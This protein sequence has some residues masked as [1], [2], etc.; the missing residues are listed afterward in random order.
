VA[1]LITDK[2]HVAWFLMAV[3]NSCQTEAV[4]VR[5]DR[6]EFT[7]T[8]L[9]AVRKHVARIPFARTV[10]RPVTTPP[11]F[12]GELGYGFVSLDSTFFDVFY[13]CTGLGAVGKHVTRIVLAFSVKCPSTAP[14]V[15]VNKH[16]LHVFLFCTGLG[17]VRK[18]VARIP[19]AR[20]VMCPCTAPLI[21]VNKS[22]LGIFLC[23][24]GLRAVLKH[25]T[26]IVL[27]RSV[28]SPSTTPP[29]FIDRIS[30][31]MGFGFILF[32]FQSF[33]G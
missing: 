5:I 30:L 12:I 11:V 8:G 33:E 20:T 21:F 10:A 7:F 6:F 25:V 31:G 13:M 32:D 9:G 16:F 1:G 24:T 18:H 3:P 17:A 4:L 2:E 15:F 28:A 19:F 22:I 14:F 29:V 26:R 27:A 23:S